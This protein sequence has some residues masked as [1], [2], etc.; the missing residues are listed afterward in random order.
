MA[1]IAYSEKPSGEA[2]K[3]LV[4]ATVLSG[5]AKPTEGIMQGS[6]IIE[7]DT[8][9]VYMFNGSSWVEEFSLQS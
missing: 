5:D 4:E 7:V 9:K 2:Q 1:F 3:K 6:L 8:G